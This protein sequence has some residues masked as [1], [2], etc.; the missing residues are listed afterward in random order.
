MSDLNQSSEELLILRWGAT[1]ARELP[2]NIQTVK[3]VL[4]QKLDHTVG[5][6]LTIGSTRHHGCEPEKRV[7]VFLPVYQSLKSAETINHHEDYLLLSTKVPSSNGQQ[8]LQVAV[9]TS[10]TTSTLASHNLFL[11]YKTPYD[12]A[13]SYLE[14]LIVIYYP[15]S[16]LCSQ[17]L[18]NTH[19]CFYYY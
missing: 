11:T 13:P 8:S 6:G 10:S 1:R 3:L 9:P 15:S 7:R 18:L 2:V 16:T 5:E 17:I 4:T 19:C 14:K 12:Q